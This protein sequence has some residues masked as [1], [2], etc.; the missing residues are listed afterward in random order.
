MICIPYVC[1]RREYVFL[2]SLGELHA[3]CFRLPNASMLECAYAFLMIRC[4]IPCVDIRRIHFLRAY[5]TE[6]EEGD[7]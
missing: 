2:R 4:I 6:N 1:L 7:G 3:T 5:G